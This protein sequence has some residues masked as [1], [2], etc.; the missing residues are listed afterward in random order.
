MEPYANMAADYGCVTIAR[1]EQTPVEAQHGELAATQSETL[2][3]ISRLEERLSHVLVSEL[4]TKPSENALTSSA[5]PLA[6]M[7]NGRI[8][9]ARNINAR[10]ERL[11]GRIHL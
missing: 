10:L 5:T 11:L 6:E 1:R 8:D 7:L 4:P 2:A 9:G 3:I